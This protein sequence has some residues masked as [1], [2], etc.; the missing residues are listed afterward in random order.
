MFLLA[1]V[2]FFTSSLGA[3]EIEKEKSS[4]FFHEASE[5]ALS[6]GAG[7]FFKSISYLAKLG[8]GI[9]CLSAVDSSSAHEC[10]LLS[11]LATSISQH[12]FTKEPHHKPYQSSWLLNEL[13]L[14]TIS[15]GCEED[16]A[17]LLFLKNL[18]FLYLLWCRFFYS[19]QHD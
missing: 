18:L 8:W 10:L 9:Q 5:E 4:D 15:A 17:L 11:N 12:F 2:L 16:A 19:L 13:Q 7:G 3:S 14:S 6:L 1:L